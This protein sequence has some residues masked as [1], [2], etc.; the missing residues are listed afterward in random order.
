MN[1]S[2]LSSLP[3]G[4][5]FQHVVG[6]SLIAGIGFTMS[7]FIAT[8]GF[9]AQSVNLQSAKSSILFA[10][11]VSATLGILFLRFVATKKYNT[12]SDSTKKSA[13]K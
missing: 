2:Y 4:V 11:L 13:V 12:S 6:I 1:F 8:L 9:D 7:T 5:N 10:S 3:K